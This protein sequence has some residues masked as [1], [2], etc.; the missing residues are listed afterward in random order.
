VKARTAWGQWP[1]AEAVINTGCDTVLRVSISELVQAPT[2]NNL[3]VEEVHCFEHAGVLGLIPDRV[4]KVDGQ[5]VASFRPDA[6]AIR[7]AAQA[8]GITVEMVAPDGA[9]FAMRSQYAVD[10]V[11]PVLAGATAGV[12]CQILATLIAARIE[13]CMRRSEKPP[14]VA[15]REVIVEDGKVQ[16]R[17]LRGPAREVEQLLRKRAESGDDSRSEP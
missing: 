9:E 3:S 11:L 17:E 12:P 5:L 6:Q 4:Y 1:A 8:A 7:V 2:E 15:F 16:E 13:G 14:E 10:W